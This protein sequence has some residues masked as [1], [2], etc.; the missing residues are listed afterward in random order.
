M[1]TKEFDVDLDIKGN[2]IHHVAYPT[3]NDDGANK[4]FVLDNSNNRSFE[5][6]QSVA[7]SVWN[8]T[9]NLNKLYPNITIMDT[10]SELIIGYLVTYVD[11]NTVQLTFSAAFSGR[12]ILS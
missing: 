8:I 4:Q 3:A 6:D 10:T 9:H 7:A 12:A 1:A 11:V 5:F 2:A